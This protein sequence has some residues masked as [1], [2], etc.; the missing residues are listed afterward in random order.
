[1]NLSEAC[2]QYGFLVPVTF[3]V[4][5]LHCSV[6]MSQ[7]RIRDE[8]KDE[9]DTF[10]ILGYYMLCVR[11]SRGGWGLGNPFPS[12]EAFWGIVE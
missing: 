12:I 5:L 3:F 2:K 11:V 4:S 6:L 10:D 7:R 9:R 1:M 8:D